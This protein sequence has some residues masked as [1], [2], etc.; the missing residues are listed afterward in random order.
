M[1]SPHLKE[2]FGIP[3]SAEFLFLVKFGDRATSLPSSVTV[4]TDGRT[5]TLSYV[6]DKRGNIS[7]IRENGTLVAR[8]EYDALGRLVRE[9]NRAL[10]K[11]ELTVYDENGNI[12]SRKAFPYTV[13]SV[14]ALTPTDEKL[15]VYESHDA[16]ENYP[17]NLLVSF[18]GQICAYDAIGNPTTY[19]GKSVVWERSRLLSSF[20]GISYT[21]DGLGRCTGMGS[22]ALKYDHSGRV[23]SAKGLRVLYDE[24]GILGLR[25]SSDTFYYA[26]K[27]AQGKNTPHT[28]LI[29]SEFAKQTEP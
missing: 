28:W 7:E 22:D 20:D 13:E 18:N 21:Y 3:P 1:F 17:H 2:F 15:Y 24:S 29:R 16:W 8:Y 4:K 19:R 5:D 12:L 23:I 11:T 9:D 10:D 26:K 6:Y 25:D 14:D 27:D